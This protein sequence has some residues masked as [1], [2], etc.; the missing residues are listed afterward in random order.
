MSDVKELI[1]QY[2]AENNAAKQ[3]IQGLLKLLR[4]ITVMYQN[5]KGEIRIPGKVRKQAD[6]FG[7]EIKPLKTSVVLKLTKKIEE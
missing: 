3:Q 7:L 6:G 5:D 2:A 4:D 1:D